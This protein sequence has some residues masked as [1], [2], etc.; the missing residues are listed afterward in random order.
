MTPPKHSPPFKI[1]D[2]L[3]T[4]VSKL[5]FNGGRG[6]ARFNN[7]VIFV[8]RVLP[9]E[10]VRIKI[11]AIQK[12]FAEAELL[13][14]LQPSSKRKSPEC[15]YFNECNGCSWQHIEYSDQLEFKKIIF[16]EFLKDFK[17]LT[18]LEITASPQPFFYRNRIQLHK[19]DQ[20]LGYHKRNSK[21]LVSIEECVIADEKINESLSHLKS[22]ENG[23]YEIYLDRNGQ[24][25]YRKQD[26]KKEALLFS[27]VNEAVN[28]LMVQKTLEWIQDVNPKFLLELYSGAGN[29]TFALSKKWPNA[30]IVAIE[31]SKK[32]VD[33]AK[34]EKKDQIK[35][36]HADLNLGLSH[37]KKTTQQFDCALIDPPR[38]GASRQVLS[39]IVKLNIPNIFYISC[40]PPSLK[41]DLSYLYSQGYEPTR[42]HLFDMFPQTDHIESLVHIEKRI[43]TSINVQLKT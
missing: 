32:L 30:Q 15:K 27:Q 36:I 41:R 20:N 14:I 1:G 19:V 37:L 31:G 24:V 9:E 34:R 35:F 10:L 39:D 43:S 13:E 11:S 16:M 7:F 21:D 5:S 29:F 33:L 8:P 12:N 4:Q 18:S 2:I 28:K 42:V 25:D 22:L 3:E 17:E 23:R 38:D 26:S 40:N 6:I